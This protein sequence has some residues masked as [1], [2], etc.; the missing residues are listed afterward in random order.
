MTAGEARPRAAIFFFDG[1]V[2]I[3]VSVM[4]AA[5]EL[6]ARGYAVDL[7]Y[8]EP[9]FAIAPPQ[10]IPGVTFHAHRPWTRALTKAPLS[11]LRRRALRKLAQGKTD[12]GVRKK[13]A[14]LR[15]TARAFLTFIE[16]PQFARFCRRHVQQTDLAIAFD[17]NSL[18]VMDCVLPVTTPF[19]YWSLEIWRLGDL[20]DPL[21]R[22]MKRHELTR[23]RDAHAVVVQSAVRRTIIEADLD[24]PLDNYVEVPN[25]PAN[26]MPKV[27]Q[28]DFYTS[29]FPIPGDALVVLH[30][31]FIS[32]SLLSLEIAQSVASWP[33]SFVLIFH[34]RQKRDPREPYIRAVQEAGGART[35]LSLSP[36][37]FEDVDNV[38]AGADIGL[39]C[40]QTAEIN[41]ATAW[42]SSGKLT[43]YLRHGM[44]IVIVM[45]ECPPFLREW[46][47]GE[48]ARDTA[49]IGQALAR[50]AADYDVYSARAR[51]TYAALYDFGQAFDR[52]MDRVKAG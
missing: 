10:P 38:Y 18:T 25:A 2:S 52:L 4:G 22:A 51:A 29:R 37:P 24:R 41:E 1:W 21:S 45:P 48:W 13:S 9:A 42:A 49:G 30:S 31:G 44:P 47:C 17:M 16:I 14:R 35:F 15:A 11:W 12:D 46:G 6:A 27:L 19:I 5:S 50:I 34:E 28:R 40:Y 7:F 39:V 32:T 20:I 3:S 23:L 33:E 26:P 36:V 8:N 43:Y